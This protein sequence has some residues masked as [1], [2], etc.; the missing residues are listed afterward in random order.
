MNKMRKINFIILFACLL[1]SCEH[2][3]KKYFYDSGELWY[4]TYDIDKTKGTYYAKAYYKNGNLKEE[5]ANKKNG[6]KKG[7]GLRVD[8]WKMYYSDGV[9][10]WEGDYSDGHLIISKDGKWPDFLHTRAQLCI[11]G[12]NLKR[13][14]VG[15]TYRIRFYIRDVH[16]SLYVVSSEDCL[17]QE[18]NPDERDR[19]PYIIKPKHAGEL[20]INLIFPDEKGYFI[21]KVPQLSFKLKVEE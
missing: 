19:F 8:H 6:T 3:T 5:G 13:I 15:K 9:L 21:N 4:E 2:K 14:R 10:M 17:K 11:E 16:P 7:K 20:H 12:D 18:T 1:I